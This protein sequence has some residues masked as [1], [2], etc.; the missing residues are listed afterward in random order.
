M[1]FSYALVARVIVIGTSLVVICGI[2]S[3]AVTTTGAEIAV[4]CGTTSSA[5]TSGVASISETITGADM[6]VKSA[7]SVS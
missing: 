5:V 4:T 6:T 7:G 3:I 2:T 1:P